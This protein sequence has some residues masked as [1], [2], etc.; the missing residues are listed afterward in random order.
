MI[1]A[2]VVFIQETHCDSMKTAKKLSQGWGGKCFWSFGTNTSCGLGILVNK[3]LVNHIKSF[4]FDYEGRI[5]SVNILLNN[6]EHN[7]QMCI[8]LMFQLKEKPSLIF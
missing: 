3:G 6:V 5:V 7:F 1:K 2:D 8:V 4:S